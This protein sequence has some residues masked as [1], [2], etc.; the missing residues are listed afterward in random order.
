LN[1]SLGRHIIVLSAVN[2]N[3]RIPRHLPPRHPVMQHLTASEQY[4]ISNILFNA[5]NS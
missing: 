2:F 3:S 5:R 1:L 4:M